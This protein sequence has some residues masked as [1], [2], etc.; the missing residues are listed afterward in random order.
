M[1]CVWRD[2]ERPLRGRRRREGKKGKRFPVC[3]C[4]AVYV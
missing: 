1:G 2:R 3:V 4:V